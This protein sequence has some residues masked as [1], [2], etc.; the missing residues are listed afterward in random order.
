[1]VTRIS[2]QEIIN[3]LT[4]QK[5]QL[6]NLLDG[7]AT[8]GQSL[9]QSQW[10]AISRGL[11]DA[12][13]YKGALDLT[14]SLRKDQDQLARDLSLATR[15]NSRMERADKGRHMLEFNRN[16]HDD[17]QNPTVE[18]FFLLKQVDSLNESIAQAQIRATFRAEDVFFEEW[19][20]NRPQ[21]PLE[22]GQNIARLVLESCGGALQRLQGVFSGVMHNNTHRQ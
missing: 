20:E 8:A 12:P 1:M 21:S 10:R 7:I 13:E 19:M 5:Q 3:F 14:R 9:D 6:A 16:L 17:S 2:N 22:I 18:I 4:G 11:T 15:P